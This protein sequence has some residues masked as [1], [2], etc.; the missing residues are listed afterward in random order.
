MT[1]ELT[2]SG[3]QWLPD[4]IMTLYYF[5]I[6]LFSYSIPCNFVMQNLAGIFKFATS[7]VSDK[8]TSTVLKHGV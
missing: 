7:H 8:L 3:S 6:F 2:G 1:N 4:K 5:F